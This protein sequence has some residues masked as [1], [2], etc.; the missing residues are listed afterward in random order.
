MAEDETIELAMLYPYA[1]KGQ[2]MIAIVSPFRQ[3]A[4]KPEL[5]GRRVRIEDRQYKVLSIGRVTQGP[6]YKGE[7][8]GIVV[9]PT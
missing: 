5:V 7:I 1:H 6:I 9:E 8:V 4:A 3:D 2:D